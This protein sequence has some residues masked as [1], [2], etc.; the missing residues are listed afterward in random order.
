M[1]V[2]S[3]I[4]TCWLVATL[5][6]AA[7]SL[8]CDGA[9]AGGDAGGDER[10]AATDR[11]PTSEKDSPAKTATAAD[12][13]PANSGRIVETTFDDLKFPME[14]TETF[15][16]SML[17]DLVKSRF[18]RNIRLRGYMFPTNRSKGLKQFVLVRDN[19]E[20]CFGPGAAL[21][22]CVC[23]TMREGAT[24]EFSTFPI[25]VEGE[26]RLDPL[27]G[28]DGRPMAIYQMVGDAVK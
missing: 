28:P 27:I 23:V 2:A 12:S 26:F 18:G 15:A 16:E 20:C 6:A 24:A 9:A 1:N 19:Q 4:S 8:G 10:A 17:T 22:D 5:A 13:A 7:V 25:A 14:K 3:R 11:E 21:F